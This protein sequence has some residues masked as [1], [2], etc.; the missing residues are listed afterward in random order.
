MK[1][2]NVYLMH[3]QAILQD[4][5]FQLGQG[6]TIDFVEMQNEEVFDDKYYLD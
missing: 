6:N 2:S 1:S 4:D 3:S 5:L